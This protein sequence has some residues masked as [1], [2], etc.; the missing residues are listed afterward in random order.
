MLCI[1]SHENNEKKNTNKLTFFKVNFFNEGDSLLRLTNLWPSDS[2]SNWNL[3][4]SL[5]ARTRTNNK[6]NPH[7]V[8]M[9][10]ATVF[11]AAVSISVFQS[12]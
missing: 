1:K 8:P 11:L 2:R 6:L 7:N 9:S 12:K 4:K 3:E 10:F 5:G